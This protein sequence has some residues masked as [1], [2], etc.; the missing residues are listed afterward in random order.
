MARR[1]VRH[2]QIN[3]SDTLISTVRDSI[4]EFRSI[5]LFPDGTFSGW[6]IENNFVTS[7]PGRTIFDS[8]KTLADG[9]KAP[10]MTLKE[11]YL[12]SASY[13]NIRITE[14]DTDGS[15]LKVRALADKPRRG[16]K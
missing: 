1:L 3:Y 12:Q 13:H 4:M 9:L 15:P 10:W 16:K 5:V 14:F 6:D 11:A 7:G 8:L 2:S